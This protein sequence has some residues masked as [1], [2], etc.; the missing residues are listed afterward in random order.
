MARARADLP[1]GIRLRDRIGLGVIAKPFPLDRGPQVLADT[2]KARERDLPAHV[3]VSWALGQGC[4]LIR[5]KAR[6]TKPASLREVLSLRKTIRVWSF[7]RQKRFSIRCLV[8]YQ[9]RSC[10][11]GTFR[12]RFDGITASIP[13]SAH[14][15]T[16]ALSNRMASVSWARSPIRQA[17]AT[18][19]SN[20]SVWQ[21]AHR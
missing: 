7:T 12:F 20:V 5:A 10:G 14:R 6:L 4:M 3:M 1:A 19:S 9:A 2:G 11:I 17:D 8:R 16:A 13:C 18:S 21:R 15:W